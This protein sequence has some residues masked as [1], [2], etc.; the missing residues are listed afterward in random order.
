MSD[1]TSGPKDEEDTK[2]IAR[3]EKRMVEAAGLSDHVCAKFLKSV[4]PVGDR[5]RSVVN[6][7]MLDLS[8][9]LR[10]LWQ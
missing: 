4:F 2:D 7:V 5:N 3:W 8:L 9:A 1:E 6:I 10:F